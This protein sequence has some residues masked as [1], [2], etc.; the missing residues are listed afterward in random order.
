MKNYSL[1]VLLCFLVLNVFSGDS[2]IKK[3]FGSDDVQ[4]VKKLAHRLYYITAIDQNFATVEYLGRKKSQ[5]TFNSMDGKELWK[6]SF[7]RASLV[8]ISEGSDKILIMANLNPLDEYEV[9][10]YDKTGNKLWHTMVTSPGLTQ[11]PGGKYAIT[12]RISEAEMRGKF[13]IFDMAKGIEIPVNMPK[14][15]GSFI[16]A[17]FISGEQVAL[18]MTSVDA[19]RVK[20]EPSQEYLEETKRL[21]EERNYEE[22]AKLRGKL[23]GRTYSVKPGKGDIKY[24]LYDIPE[25]VIKFSKILGQE[26]DHR[27]LVDPFNPNRL[28]SSENGNYISTI[29]EPMNDGNDIKYIS[30]FESTGQDVWKLETL[31]EI[32]DAVFID[33]RFFAIMIGDRGEN[34]IELYSLENK[35]KIFERVI[36]RCQLFNEIYLNDNEMVIQTGAWHYTEKHSHLYK[37]DWKSGKDLSPEIDKNKLVL[38]KATDAGS[39]IFDKKVNDLLYVR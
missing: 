8:S 2:D 20:I 33:N 15:F 22:L 1:I 6:K 38:I 36:E 4:V 19:E 32:K 14:E 35:K 39:L 17:K 28:N 9:S 29:Y 16:H 12:T 18:I 21:E 5:V 3:I 27:L 7:E 10:C 24:V 11:G 13:Q 23:I 26:T 37:I 30:I 31:P 25:G 34:R